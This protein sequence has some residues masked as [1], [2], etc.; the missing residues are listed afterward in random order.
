MAVLVTGAAGFIGSHVVAQ[1]LQS[2]AQVRA[3]VR[4]P[5]NA[6]FLNSLPVANGA[7]LQ[8]VTMDLLDLLVF[9]VQFLIV[10]TLSIVLLHSLLEQMTLRKIS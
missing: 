3:T 7:S 2:G 8:I 9:A 5:K 4:N 10:K 6:I 1:L